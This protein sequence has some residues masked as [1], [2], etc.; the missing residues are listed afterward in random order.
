MRLVNKDGNT[1]AY[2]DNI[3]ED[4]CIIKRVVNGEFTLSFDAL[5]S[6]LKS[7]YFNTDG[8]IVV[9]DQTFSISYIEKRHNDDVRYKLKCEHVNYKM[10]DGDDNKYT[11]Y[12][13]TGTPTE[14][15]T[16]I[17]KDTVFNVGEVDFDEQITITVNNEITRKKLIYQLA[18]L[19]G[20]EIDYT[21]LGYTIN[22]KD[23]IGS[24]NGYEV[25]FGKNMLGVTKTIDTRGDDTISY[26]VNV[27]MLKH[28]NTY[29]DLGLSDLEQ[30]GV[31]DTIRIIDDVINLDVENRVVSIEY[32]PIN[33][34][35]VT[36][37]IANKLKLISDQITQIETKAE[38]SVQVGKIY[39]NATVSHAYGFRSESTD[40][41]SRATLGGTG[42]T[43]E[44]G[45][46]S[47]SYTKA[48]WFDAVTKKYNFVG[49]VKITGGSLN[50]NDNFIVNDQGHVTAKNIKITGSDAINIDSVQGAGELAKKD[51]LDIDGVRGAEDY[52]TEISEYAITTA[53]I[54]AWQITGNEFTALSRI[55][56]GKRDDKDKSKS[57][58]FAQGQRLYTYEGAY[59]YTNI[60]LEATDIR[61]S[62]N[63]L[64]LPINVGNAYS[65]TRFG[66]DYDFNGATLD[67]SGANVYGIDSGGAS[68]TYVDN[69]IEKSE[70]Y[71]K[72][73]MVRDLSHQGI[74]CQIFSDYI[75]F[76]ESGGSWKV[77]YFDN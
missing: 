68:E 50:I 33:N 32:D 53:Q 77:L 13:K 66:G 34:V 40:K 71:L 75:E 38:K 5:E 37:E 51:Y 16:D 60:C 57:L 30:V 42:L 6:E 54:N 73:R 18:N 22:L 41:K 72:R 43:L 17:L 55:T 26:Q 12:A 27:L 1:L 49:D 62:C 61:M 36:L 10:E 9:D 14:I 20:A 15:L 52:V 48:L 45:D 74:E 35:N 31:G 21:D 7:E 63:T 65:I 2:L 25:R 23:T 47:G 11:V 39:N 8:A 4:T 67:F 3:V 58:E 24:K 69:A 29:K 76:R 56:I 44:T 19:I 64:E 70:S 28:S 59:G 46:G